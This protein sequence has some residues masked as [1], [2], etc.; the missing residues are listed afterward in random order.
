MAAA[1][2]I[3]VTGVP[4]Y[5][6][7]VFATGPLTGNPV[8]L[9]PDADHLPEAQMRAIAR[10]FNQSETVFLLRPDLPTATWRLRSF[11]PIGAEVFGAGHHALGAWI[12]LAAFGRLPAASSEFTQQIGQHVLPVSVVQRPESG[13]FVS[14]QQSSPRFGAMIADRTE[15]A[16]ALNLTDK[17]L[18]SEP[19]P[20]VVSTGAEHLM[21]PLRDQAAVDRASPHS[22]QL[23]AALRKVDAEGCYIYTTEAGQVDAC[24]RFFN[25]IMGI[26]EDP[27]T[28]T[29]A[30]PLAA[31]LRHTGQAVHSRIVIEQGHALGRPSLIQVTVEDERVT[32][33][34]SG[35][36]AAEGHLLL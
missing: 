23:A 10:E 28:A 8:A 15:L 3:D 33:S 32:V 20:Q 21:V 36:M 5:L 30:G 14:M 13:I 18:A 35:V 1:E 17:D 24:T 27:A 12:W 9:V 31:L 19:A 34:G 26:P 22:T 16:A 4:F 25:P 7:D 2:S 29:A 11:T 6:I